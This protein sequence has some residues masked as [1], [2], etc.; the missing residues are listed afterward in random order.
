MRSR[1][2]KYAEKWPGYDSRKPRQ[3]AGEED[4]PAVQVAE[5]IPAEM[6][7]TMFAVMLSEMMGQIAAD[8]DPTV[9]LGEIQAGIELTCEQDPAKARD[10]EIW[11][12]QLN[13]SFNILPM[14]GPAFR[15]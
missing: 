2:R 1:P 9:T 10:L 13:Q 14:D 5:P 3:P 11:L 8:S 12:D 4:V 15:C 7:R 6:Q